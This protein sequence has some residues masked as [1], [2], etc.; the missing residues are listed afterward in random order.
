MAKRRS[1]DEA[2]I[3]KSLQVT[4]YLD[5]IIDKVYNGK[6]ITPDIVPN[7]QD[8]M[9]QMGKSVASESDSPFHIDDGTMFHAAASSLGSS[10]ISSLLKN[11]SV[12]LPDPPKTAV[13]QVSETSSKPA[14]KMSA[15]QYQALQKYPALIEFLGSPGGESL[16][17]E[18]AGKVAEHM[19]NRIANNSK[20]ISKY[21]QICV[22]EKQNIKQYFAGE[23]N[24]WVCVVTASGP[25]RGDEAFFY[26]QDEDRAFIVR[27][28]SNKYE[29]ITDQFNVIHEF[30]DVEESSDE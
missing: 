20:E 30:A 1:G 29:D 16:V 10:G 25:F 14:F 7:Y 3:Q 28:I 15:N 27:K 21:A 17:K 11:A 13:T 9:A 5:S 19:V 23:N 18:I 22:A 8:P 12:D 26:K 6:E 4:S 2:E 24:E